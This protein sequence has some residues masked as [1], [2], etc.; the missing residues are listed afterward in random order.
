MPVF[1]TFPY[2]N[3]HE[4]NLDWILKEVK[5]WEHVYDGIPAEIDKYIANVRIPHLHTTNGFYIYV[6]D[7]TGDDMNDGL[8]PER[9][10][11]TLEQ[12][13]KIFNGHTALANIYLIE[14]GDYIIPYATIAACELHITARAGGVRVFWLEDPTNTKLKTFYNC[15]LHLG[16][17]A[18]GSTVF[19][20]SGTG[21]DTCYIEGGK[22][23]ARDID[24]ESD[25]CNFGTTGAFASFVDCE[26][27]MKVWSQLGCVNYSGCTFVPL[28]GADGRGA[29]HIGASTVAGISTSAT[30]KQLDEATTP[31]AVEADRA[32]IN[33]TGSATGDEITGNPE[34]L[35]ATR[36]SIQ[37]NQSV[38]R[39][40]LYQV[41]SVQNCEVLSKW[42]PSTTTLAGY[43]ALPVAEDAVADT[44]YPVD[45][46]AK[47]LTFKLELYDSDTM[48]A[49]TYWN[50][51]LGAVD[52]TGTMDFTSAPF[53]YSGDLT[54]N[55]PFAFWIKGNTFANGDVRWNHTFAS[56]LDATSSANT[57]VYDI[58]VSI[59]QNF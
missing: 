33:L 56:S 13:F 21:N 50:I 6:G 45:P 7:I 48:L 2:T 36:C 40:W 9:P 23:Y 29:L 47:S 5:N 49:R 28:Q 51:D 39:S 59:Y 44:R 30:F 14:P 22:I 15:Y 1:E 3:F 38:V 41:G 4:L 27:R 32:Y 57:D 35:H 37:G 54:S 11:K 52:T 26:F 42:Y 16:G 25:G 8:V 10:V 12:A 55:V 20:I 19:H 58:K 17:Y 34:L 31:Y 24:F 53:I 18:D 43:D 46:N